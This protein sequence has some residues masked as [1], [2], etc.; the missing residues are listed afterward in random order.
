[1]QR[2]CMELKE[3]LEI[4]G[5]RIWILTLTVFVITLAA[6]LVSLNQ[7]TKYSGSASFYVLVT[8]SSN[9]GNI[10]KED[11]FKYNN[12]YAIQSGSLFTDI[13]SSWIKD[14]A[15]VAEIYQNAGIEIPPVGINSYS[16]FFSVKKSQ[17]ATLQ[18]TL[19]STNKEETSKLL[20]SAKNFIQ[21]KTRE[22][23]DRGLINNVS[24]DTTDSIIVTQPSSDLS[25][26]AVGFVIGIILGLVF[27]FFS[28]YMSTKNSR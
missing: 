20:E 18:L 9:V 24:L 6:Y 28:Q 7:P 11:F 22:W 5:R 3:Y 21:N 26:T 16:R 15:N 12:Y 10:P 8:D 17:P 19:E 23:K 1:M 13:I 14:P 25:N 2:Y 4:I 27:V